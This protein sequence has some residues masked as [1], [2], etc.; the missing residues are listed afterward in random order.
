MAKRKNPK[1]FKTVAEEAGSMVFPGVRG[2]LSMKK[3]LNQL[4]KNN[5]LKTDTVAPDN[6]LMKAKYGK[7]VMK[8]RGGTFKGTF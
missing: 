1:T 7:A 2:A 8:K 5:E 3:V 6:R 4:K